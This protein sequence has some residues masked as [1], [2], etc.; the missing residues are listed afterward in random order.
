MTKS[1]DHQER[2]AKLMKIPSTTKLG[3]GRFIDINDRF[4]QEMIHMESGQIE[5]Q[6][7]FILPHLVVNND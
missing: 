1:I 3:G 7:D 4:E 6:P 5:L 2:L